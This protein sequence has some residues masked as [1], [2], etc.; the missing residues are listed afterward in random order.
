[1]LHPPLSTCLETPEVEGVGQS[2]SPEVIIIPPWVKTW[3]TKGKAEVGEPVEEGGSEDDMEVL[4]V[5]RGSTLAFVWDRKLDDKIMKLVPSEE[6]DRRMVGISAFIF[7]GN[8]QVMSKCAKRW[9]S[10]PKKQKE[11]ESFD[12]V[13]EEAENVNVKTKKD[14]EG[15]RQD[16]ALIGQDQDQLRPTLQKIKAKA[17]KYKEAKKNLHN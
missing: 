10:K 8:A 9:K 11:K 16:L 7:N 1:M 2:G 15:A 6:D 14:L 12:K 4:E 5:P 3:V 13:K 17:L